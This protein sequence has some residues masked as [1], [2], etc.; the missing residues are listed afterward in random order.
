[1]EKEM[2]K[3]TKSLSLPIKQCKQNQHEK[4][5]Q[6]AL[7]APKR[8]IRSTRIKKKASQTTDQ[9]APN[10]KMQKE[11]RT[12]PTIQPPSSKTS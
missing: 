9:T 4:M 12:E 10:T 3:K 11:T 5:E 6:S 1:M 8:R 2:R 7:N